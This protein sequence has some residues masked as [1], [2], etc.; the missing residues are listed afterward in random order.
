MTVMTQTR[1]YEV[2]F[3]YYESIDCFIVENGI[4]AGTFHYFY[5]YLKWMEKQILRI[6]LRL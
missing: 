4:A 6:L 5:A 2:I 1:K 3:Y